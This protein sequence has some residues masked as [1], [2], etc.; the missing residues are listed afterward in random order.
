MA[1]KSDV[2]LY[3]VDRSADVPLY[4]FA[5]GAEIASNLGIILEDKSYNTQFKR[6]L[7]KDRIRNNKEL[8]NFYQTVKQK[9]PQM[10]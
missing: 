1:F 5:E 8:M 3:Y 4:D 10:K 2:R 7:F 6:I 9:C